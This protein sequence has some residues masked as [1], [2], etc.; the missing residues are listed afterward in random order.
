MTRQLV[1]LGVV[2]AAAALTAACGGSD[3]REASSSTSA[4]CAAAVEWQGTTY[5]GETVS[6]PAELGAQLGEGQIP[7]CSDTPG[8]TP[9]ASQPVRL[10][11]VSG[12]PREQAVAVA[13][14][15]GHVYLAPGYFPQLPGTPLHDLV[16]ARSDAPDE[17]GGDCDGAARVDVS[18]VVRSASFGLLHVTL[19]DP[20][21][22]LPRDATIFPDARTDIEEG[23][24]EPH[25]E[26]GD[27]IRAEVLV[28]RH[29][30]DPH[31]LKLVATR[32]ELG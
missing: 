31:F 17:R 7:S 23:G 3:V 29:A 8:G 13:G 6:T 25:V 22:E 2:S 14:D 24:N 32:I 20:P 9:T 21:D 10:V 27:A 11:V 4:M 1:C 15:M 5:V 16:Y 19:D 18:A 26:P 12:V 30:N 28:C